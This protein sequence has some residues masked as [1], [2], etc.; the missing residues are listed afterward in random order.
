MAQWASRR[1]VYLAVPGS[2]PAGGGNVFK[3]K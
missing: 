2:V 1:S 3:R